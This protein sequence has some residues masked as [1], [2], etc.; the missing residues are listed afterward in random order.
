MPRKPDGVAKVGTL[1]IAELPS[2][3]GGV[4]VG[5]KGQEGKSLL[6]V[7][8]RRRRRRAGKKK[9]KNFL[10]PLWWRWGTH[11]GARRDQRGKVFLVYSVRLRTRKK[12]GKWQQGKQFLFEGAGEG[13]APERD[14]K[15]FS[16]LVPSRA[17]A[18]P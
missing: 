4:D 3:R 1:V 2:R 14:P 8:V 13:A 12:E 15:T 16:P 5:G 6:F 9:Q 18:I 11:V 10:S 17:S 7:K